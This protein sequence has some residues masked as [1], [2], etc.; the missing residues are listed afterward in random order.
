MASTREIGDQLVAVAKVHRDDA[1]GPVG[2]EVGELRLLHQPVAG[3]QYQIGRV[4]VALELDDLGDALL[5]LERQQV[6]HVLAPRGA[7]GL[8]QV[9]GLGPV[10]PALRGEEQDPVVGGADEEVVDDV[11]LLE[12][13]ALHTLAAALL[14]AVQVGLGPLGV[15]GLGDRDDHLFAGDQVLVGD[16]PGAPEEPGELVPAPAG[17][18]GHRLRGLAGVLQAP[19]EHE[20][21]GEAGD[22]L[23]AVLE[24]LHDHRVRGLGRGLGHGQIPGSAS[25]QNG[26]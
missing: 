17:G 1:A 25:S 12:A 4:F 13:C 8:G 14:A 10:H 7:G 5:G 18:A 20:E 22:D 9:I 6:G 26:M 2:V 21:E 3:G 19:G 24:G 15:T 16:V 23:E 11:V